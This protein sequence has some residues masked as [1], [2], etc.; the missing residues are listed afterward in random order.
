V[1]NPHIFAV[2]VNTPAQKILELAYHSL[3]DEDI[4]DAE[5]A[6]DYDYVWCG[7][8][9]SNGSVAGREC[10]AAFGSIHPLLKPEIAAIFA[11]ER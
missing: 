3:A 6:P 10:T 2:P 11:M 1:Y 9:T 8:V 4:E 5:D 7:Q